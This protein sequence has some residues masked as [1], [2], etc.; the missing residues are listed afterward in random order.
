M[1]ARAPVMKPWRR[2]P[3]LFCVGGC[4]CLPL[5]VYPAGQAVFGDVR[6]N[7]GGGPFLRICRCE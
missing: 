2:N 7:Y 1:P 6:C 3:E 4:K 5:E